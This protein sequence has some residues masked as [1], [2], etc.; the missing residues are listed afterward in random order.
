MKYSR[1]FLSEVEGALLKTKQAPNTGF[2]ICH[3]VIIGVGFSFHTETEAVK[4]VSRLAVLW[5]KFTGNYQF[6][7]P[8]GSYI[9][10]QQ[11]R[12]L[13]DKSTQYG[14]NRWELLDFLIEQVQAMIQ[15]IDDYIEEHEL[16]YLEG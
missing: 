6:P 10:A 4:L 14:K 3:N 7:V 11:S 9:Q 1:N 5:P 12:T 16:E 15:E 13:W 8:G 2:G